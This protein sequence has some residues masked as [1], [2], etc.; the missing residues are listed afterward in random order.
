MADINSAQI[1]E[2]ELSDDLYRAMGLLF[3]AYRDF[4]SDPDKVLAE[5]ESDGTNMGRAHHRVIH[6]VG[7]NPGMRV[8]QLLDILQITK[9]SLSRVLR[10]LVDEGYIHQ[11]IGR[12][13]ARQR[14]LFLTEKGKRLDQSLAQPQKERLRK[15]FAEAGDDAK[16]G[17]LEMLERMINEQDRATALKVIEHKL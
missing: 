1:N 10:K 7:G 4:V 15:A 16:R 17:F 13:D 14:L 6:F 2:G 9:Q 8:A 12:R 5:I 11:E 3:F